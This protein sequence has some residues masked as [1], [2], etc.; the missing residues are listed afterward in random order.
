MH[1]IIYT[2]IYSTAG[3]G[4]YD[5]PLL[6]RKLPTSLT[7]SEASRDWL[8]SARTHRLP[9]AAPSCGKRLE[10]HVVDWGRAVDASGEDSRARGPGIASERQLRIRG[11]RWM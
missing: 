9:V 7:G 8:V 4:E 5:A 2:F 1:A 10:V 11:R 3:A 6:N